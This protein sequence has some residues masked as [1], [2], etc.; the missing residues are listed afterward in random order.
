MSPERG[1][2]YDEIADWYENEFLGAP[3]ATPEEPTADP[4][5]IYASLEHLLG[6]G[7]ST[8]VEIGC[9]TGV[10]SSWL[11]RRGWNPVGFDISSGMLRYAAPRLPVARADAQRLPVGTGSVPAVVG[12]MVHTDMPS[13]PSVLREVARVLQPGGV[14]VHVGVHPCFCGGFADRTDP[15]AIVIQPGYSDGH[16]TKASYTDRGVRN[17]VGATH[18]PLPDLLAAFLAADLAFEA[19]A[20]GGQPTPTVLA[21]RLRKPLAHPEPSLAST[22]SPQPVR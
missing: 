8:C 21:M 22:S 19:F 10:Y 12:I 20:E 6:S 2:A 4:I 11:R 7:D 15:N 13:Y 3:A 16:W 5:G 17:R 18:Y 9:G 1:A 14:Y